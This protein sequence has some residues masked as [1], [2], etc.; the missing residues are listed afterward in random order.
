MD[1]IFFQITISNLTHALLA[2]ILFQYF[3]TLLIVVLVAQ[4]HNLATIHILRVYEVG[5][6]VIVGKLGEGHTGLVIGLWATVELFEH[7][8]ELLVSR[9]F[10]IGVG[11]SGYVFPFPFSCLI[12]IDVIVNAGVPPAPN[13]H[14]LIRSQSWHMMLLSASR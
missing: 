13:L 5:F 4:P 12:I 14:D 7:L 6:L 9:K 2:K 11:L 1:T 8:F 10:S 3:K